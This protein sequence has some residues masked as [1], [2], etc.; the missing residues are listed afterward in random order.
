[1]GITGGPAAHLSSQAFHHSALLDNPPVSVFLDLGHYLSSLH[2]FGM[3]SR[4]KFSFF[5]PP[6]NCQ[7]PTIT[8]LRL[9]GHSP[10]GLS[11]Q[12]RCVVSS[13][14]HTL[15]H[16]IL[17]LST[18]AIKDTCLN[19]Y[20]PPSTPWQPDLHIHRG[21]FEYAPWYALTQRR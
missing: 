20:L 11:T 14:T 4:L 5:S 13:R 3:V 1:M 18:L 2:V 17:R 8:F 7:S 21:S 15:T 10:L 19:S 16:S 12:N 6:H 9:F